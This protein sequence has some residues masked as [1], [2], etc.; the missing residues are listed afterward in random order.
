MGT[1]KA[2]LEIEG[3]TCLER[4]VET[5]RKA[6][7]RRIWVTTRA[8]F[9]RITTLAETCGATPVVNPEPERGMFSS[10]LLGIEAALAEEPELLHVVIFP[11]DHPFVRPET[12]SGLLEILS[13]GGERRSI[14]P[15]YDH[16]AGHP[17]VLD[18]AGAVALLKHPPHT[19]LREALR[20]AAVTR[21]LVPGKDPGVLRNCNRP[22][23]LS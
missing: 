10:V 18:R 23:D 15:E 4:V 7:C 19:S 22:G 16:R 17:I 12:V 1:P 11:V 13:R 8:D 2:L 6:G 9:P 20:E 5:C 3:A 21:G 14:Q